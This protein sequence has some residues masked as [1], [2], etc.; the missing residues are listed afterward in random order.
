M[1]SATR[2]AG[3]PWW[4]MPHRH[5]STVAEVPITPPTKG[6]FGGLCQRIGCEH[7]DARWF[8]TTNARHYC[9]ECAKTF[10]DIC[11]KQGVAPFCELHL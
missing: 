7:G 6:E 5:S 2:L 10:N 3:K 9:T 4:Q 1:S 8:N 11:R